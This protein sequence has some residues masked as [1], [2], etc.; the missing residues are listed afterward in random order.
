MMFP[1]EE[2]QR[3][4]ETYYLGHTKSGS[5]IFWQIDEKGLIREGKAM[6]YQTSGNRDKGSWAVGESFWI[7]STLVGRGVLPA[8][9]KAQQCMFGQH[10]LREANRDTKIYL[11]ESEKNAIFGSLM[12]R[13]GMWLAV[14]SSQEIGKVW[15]VRN[16]LTGC[17]SVVF[18]PDADAI[19]DWSEYI[20]RFHLPNATVNR[21]CAGH[22]GGHDIADYAHYLYWQ[23]PHVFMPKEEETIQPSA[24]SVGIVED[25]VL[26]EKKQILADMV[27]SNPAIGLLVEKFDLQLVA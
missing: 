19:N 2:V 13:E 18:V 6:K 12:F 27:E 22:A 26:R 20:E 24:S 11:V 1:A 16:I 5:V 15:K 8:N 9:T 4:I 3:V 25:S 23:N 10:L 14:G 21:F 17:R 7:Y